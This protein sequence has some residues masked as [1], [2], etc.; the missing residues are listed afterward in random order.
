[1]SVGSA[2]PRAVLRD[3]FHASP[4]CLNTPRGLRRRLGVWRL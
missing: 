3:V 1:V 2:G 4:L